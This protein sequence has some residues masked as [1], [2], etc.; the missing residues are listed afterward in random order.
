M[1]AEGNYLCKLEKEI[2]ERQRRGQVFS[3]WGFFFFLTKCVPFF[4]FK[5]Y[6]ELLYCILI[7]LLNS[8]RSWNSRV[9]KAWTDL[10]MVTSELRER[11]D[12]MNAYDIPWKP[13]Y[14]T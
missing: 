11:K 14:L 6:I 4:I 12:K 13:Y 8:W 2:E 5:N 1:I 9:L 7:I 10:T 3:L